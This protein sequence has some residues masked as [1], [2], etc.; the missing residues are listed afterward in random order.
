MLDQVAL[1]LVIHGLGGGRD[2]LLRVSGWHPN[3][4]LSPDAPAVR[5]RR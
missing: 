4:S 2:A 1:P 5:T 3:L